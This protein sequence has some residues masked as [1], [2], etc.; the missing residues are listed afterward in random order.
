MALSKRRIRRDLA[1]EAL[2]DNHRRRDIM[3][4]VL[5]S[6]SWFE[7]TL[8]SKLFGTGVRNL[9]H[10]ILFGPSALSIFPIY[11]IL[12]L[13]FSEPGMAQS[14]GLGASSRI[15]AGWWLR[16][17]GQ[18]RTCEPGIQRCHNKRRPVLRRAARDKQENEPQKQRNKK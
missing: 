2:R 18:C 10:S 11:H 1:E 8:C 13:L 12:A 7:A 4:E 9:L 16:R 6:H 17:Q 15:S 3:S 5:Q 14:I